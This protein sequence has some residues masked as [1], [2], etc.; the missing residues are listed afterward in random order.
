[1][2]EIEIYISNG[3]GEKHFSL[4]ADNNTTVL[5]LLELCRKNHDPGLIY[6]HSCHH[7]SCGS[8][9]C[10]INGRERLAC[11]TKAAD[12]EDG[13]IRVEPL[14]GFP[15]LEDCAVNPEP[16]FR[17]L[18]STWSYLRDA[19][20]ETSAATSTDTSEPNTAE[21]AASAPQRFED[22]IEC[23]ACISACPAVG[24]FKGPAYCAALFRQYRNKPKEAPALLAA[25]D[26]KEG[27]FGCQRAIECSRVC[28]N[29][30]A[31]AK[32]IQQLKQILK[33]LVL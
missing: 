15:L 4:P 17:D 3:R 28:P 20:T 23:G 32:K 25:A 11:T 27:V 13:P 21:S 24:T 5:D 7:G 30:V 12:L 31:P 33:E 22:C 1:M 6:R 18:S 14:R 19:S 26:R 29:N 9:T 2:K 8:C 16:T 10:I